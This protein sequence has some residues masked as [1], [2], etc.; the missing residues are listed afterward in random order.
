M[1][2]LLQYLHTDPR[3]E[4]KSKALQHLYQLA[5]PGSHLWP[6]GSVDSI[7]D[8]ALK[9]KSAKVLNLSL[10]KPSISSVKTIKLNSIP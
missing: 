1:T 9:T 5:K 8:M 6:S 3:W 2:L 4:V 7:V 10:S